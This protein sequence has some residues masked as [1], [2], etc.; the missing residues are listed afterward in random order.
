MHI[1]C[2]DHVNSRA[3]PGSNSEAEGKVKEAPMAIAGATGS[4]SNVEEEVKARPGS[5]SEAE[6]KVK[7]APMAFAGA[8]GSDSNAEDAVMGTP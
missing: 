8:T 2:H 1:N 4:D 5:K 7:E 6:G 3:S